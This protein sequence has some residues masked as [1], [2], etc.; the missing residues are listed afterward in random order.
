LNI[1]A[2]NVYNNSNFRN[3]N[4]NSKIQEGLID[5]D[6][7]NLDGKILQNLNY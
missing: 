3:I 6:N 1:N 7:T 4:L 2:D 5:A